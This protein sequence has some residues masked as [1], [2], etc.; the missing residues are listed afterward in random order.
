MSVDLYLYNATNQVFDSTATFAQLLAQTGKKIPPGAQAHIVVADQPTFTAVVG[1]TE[2]YGAKDF[3]VI[4]APTTFMGIA[5][6][7]APVSIGGKQPLI[8]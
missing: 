5:H 6:H 2:A 4:V 7:V 3:T 1:H 8:I